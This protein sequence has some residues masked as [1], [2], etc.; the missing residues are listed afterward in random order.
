MAF[1]AIGWHEAH[2]GAR[3]E[4]LHACEQAL[5]IFRELGDRASEAATWD[6]VG[7]VHHQLGHYREAAA[8]FHRAIDLY[9]DLTD[10]YLEADTLTHLGDTQYAANTAMAARD[11]W[12]Q[13]L[14]ILDELAH[15]DADDV[16]AKLLHL[17]PG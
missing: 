6:S 14:A 15:S 3:R 4:A 1:T 13:A 10:R 16:R 11:A 12:G 7:Y 9:R 2:L 5:P 8:C 17:G